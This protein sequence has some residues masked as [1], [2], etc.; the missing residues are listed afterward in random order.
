LEEVRSRTAR[1]R[2]IATIVAVRRAIFDGA[3]TGTTRVVKSGRVEKS[4]WKA[5]ATDA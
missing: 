1:A 3:T 2:V 5:R 4:G